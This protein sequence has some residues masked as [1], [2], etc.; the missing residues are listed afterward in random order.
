M[1]VSVKGDKS[2]NYLAIVVGINEVNKLRDK[3]FVFL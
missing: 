2:I 1:K 3:N